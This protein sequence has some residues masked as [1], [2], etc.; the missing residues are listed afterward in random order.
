MLWPVSITE[1]SFCMPTEA[2]CQIKEMSK[3]SSDGR[4]TGRLGKGGV[5]S[6]RGVS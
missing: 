6:P 5:K 3:A 2:R 4:L 1:T